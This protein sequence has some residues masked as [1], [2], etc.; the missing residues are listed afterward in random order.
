MRINKFDNGSEVREFDAGE[1]V[2]IIFGT[3][4]VRCKITEV[5]D[6]FRKQHP[7]AYIF[8]D[9]NEPIGHS[10]SEDELFETKEEA[11]EVLREMLESWKKNEHDVDEET[12]RFVENRFYT[13]TLENLRRKNTEFIGATHEGNKPTETNTPFVQKFADDLLKNYPE[14]IE[15]KDWFRCSK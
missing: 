8:Y 5:D 12:C 2:W 9:L 6:Y 10:L 1:E 4:V 11:L 7:N 15:G 14:K 13:D 3:V